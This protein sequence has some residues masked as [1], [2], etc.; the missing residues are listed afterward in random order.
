MDLPVLYVIPG[1]TVR[2]V[3]MVLDFFIKPYSL[4]RPSLGAPVFFGSVH[5]RLPGSL[6]QVTA[7]FAVDVS[8][9]DFG[10]CPREASISQKGA[11]GLYRIDSGHH[12]LGVF[13]LHGCQPWRRR[14]RVWLSQD[15]E[16]SRWV[17]WGLNEGGIGLHFDLLYAGGCCPA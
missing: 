14:W 13:T 9:G 2:T 6:V 11:I 15:R 8:V 12:S 10:W 5:Q 3:A 17:G 4:P 7:G 1:V 16:D